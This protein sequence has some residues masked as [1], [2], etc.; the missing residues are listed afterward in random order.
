MAETEVFQVRWSERILDEALRNIKANKP[1]GAAAVDQRFKDMRGAFEDAMV[2]GYETL[3][4]VMMNASEDRHVLAAA[5]VG[6]A[7]VIVTKNLDDFPAGALE[8]YG[9]DAQHPDEFLCNQWE[10]DEEAMAGV[11]QHWLADL[12]ESLTLQQLLSRLERDV[13]RFCQLVR[14][15]GLDGS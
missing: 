5:I 12:G 10:L 3:E 6:R 8:P 7:D 14:A 2:T 4:P 13:P 9:I 15:A 11:M 1:G